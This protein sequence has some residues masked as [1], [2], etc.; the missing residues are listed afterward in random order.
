[1]T[2]PSAVPDIRLLI[3]D[4]HRLF[5]EGLKALISVTGGLHVIAEAE[6]GQEAL[7]L[8][9]LHDVQVVIMDIQMPILSGLEATKRLL[10]LKPDLGILV[11]SMFDD[12]DN[13]FAAMQAGARGYLLKGAAPEELLRG[14]EAVAQGEALFAPSIARRLMN[15][16]SRPTRLPPTLLPELTE[17]EREILSHIAQGET[18]PRIARRLELSEKTVRNHITSIFSKLQVSSRAE[19]TQRAKEAGL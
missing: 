9:I 17:R 16:F 10:A 6:N 15:Y 14:I 8:A 19:A 7:D 12:D 1:M 5:R 11:V 13:V 18:N 3:A 2:P 4:D